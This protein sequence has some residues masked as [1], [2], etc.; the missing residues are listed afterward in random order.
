MQGF[1]IFDKNDRLVVCNEAYRKHPP[2]PSRDLIVPGA[3]F[4]EIIRQGAERGQY[5]DAV[6]RIDEWVRERVR[7]NQAAD[8]RHIEQLL[9]DGRWLLIVEY[10]TPG[11]YIVGNRIDI[12][13][14][15][16]TESELD[17][18]RNDLEQ[19]VAERTSATCM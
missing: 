18:H 1:T 4:E 2:T 6:G 19:L 3:S 11:G 5:K 13:A 16:R 8:G 9:D 14:R 7:Q 10:R 12:S 15:K 17:R